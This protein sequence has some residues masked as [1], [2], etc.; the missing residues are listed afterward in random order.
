LT[1][2]RAP[3]LKKRERAAAEGEVGLIL[4]H[5]GLTDRRRRHFFGSGDHG[6][7]HHNG[8]TALAEVEPR[9]SLVMLSVR[10]NRCRNCPHDC[11]CDA[12]KQRFQGQQE[13]RALDQAPAAL[14]SIDARQ[15]HVVELRFFSGLNID[16][17]AEALG[18]SPATVERAWALAK[19]WLFRR[20][21]PQQ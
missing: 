13:V 7:C 2:R 19:A 14:A 18:M 4:A 8:H 9:A 12:P 10:S 6:D 5:I 3:D 17:A 20:L 21:S 1:R 16:E 15:S 11:P